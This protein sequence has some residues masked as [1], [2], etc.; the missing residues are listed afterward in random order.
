M[1]QEAKGI[2]SLESLINEVNDGKEQESRFSKTKQQ[3]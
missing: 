3:V 2:K 1:L